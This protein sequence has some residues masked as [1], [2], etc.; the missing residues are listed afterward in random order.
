MRDALILQISR[1][2]VDIIGDNP[3][4][5]PVRQGRV[6]FVVELI[7]QNP[8]ESIQQGQYKEKEQ[9]EEIRGQ[10]RG[11]PT[12]EEQRE[13]RSGGENGGHCH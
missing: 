11:F 12:T 2:M 8:K 1:D 5:S 4:S 10:G 3:T 6:G 7:F 13:V 9:R